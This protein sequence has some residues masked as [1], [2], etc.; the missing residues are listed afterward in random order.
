MCA[1]HVVP[2]V[3]SEQQKGLAQLTHVLNDDAAA[4]AVLEGRSN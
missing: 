1:G 4:V 3:L 2:Q